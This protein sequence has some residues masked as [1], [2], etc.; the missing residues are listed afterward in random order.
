VEYVVDQTWVDFQWNWSE[1]LNWIE[2]AGTGVTVHGMTTFYFLVNGI[3][4]MYVGWMPDYFGRRNTVMYAVGASL[5]VQLVYMGD[6]FHPM[7]YF[8][9][10]CLALCNV[11]NGCSYVWAFE[12]TGAKNK[13]F[14]TT[15][16]MSSI[17]RLYL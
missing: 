8:C 6:R 14:M 16:M 10:F 7:R 11:K 4:G 13:V 2:C 15:V 17:A 12:L 9:Y 5:L 3:S 1:E